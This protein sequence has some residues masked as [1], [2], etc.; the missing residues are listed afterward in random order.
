M[1]KINSQHVVFF[2]ILVGLTIVYNKMKQCD[3]VTSAEHHYKMVDEF[4]LQP[5][6]FDKPY[7]W[8]H[9]HNDSTTIPEVNARNWVS[10]YS[11]DTKD[12][13]QPYQYLT[14]KSIID[15]CGDDFNV[16]IID[17]RSFAK[18][19]PNWKINLGHVAIPIKAHLRQLALMVLVNTYG[20]MIVPSS[21]LC[22][23]SL[24]PLYYANQDQMFVAEFSNQT[25]SCSLNNRFMPTTDFMGSNAGNETLT[26]FIKYL[27]V[28]NSQDFTADRDLVGKPNLWIS[29]HIKKGHVSLVD[30]G[31]IGTKKPCGNTV[32][33]E[34]LLGSTYVELHE[35][36]FGL[37]IPWD[38][39]INR[40]AFQWFVALTPREV[41]E[42]N[43]L[44]AKYLLI[45]GTPR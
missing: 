21:F 41:L 14:V 3:D 43:T 28:L 8:I 23:K 31:L 12:F 26:E 7:L 29:D 9:M 44:I 22:F 6:A 15:K 19:I 37:Y 36:A 40:T 24:K 30:G 16:A 39:F 45:T 38:Q 4:L 5:T 42:S 10:F 11:R 2:L 20:G 18:I 25:S 35:D 13:N 32:E 33:I 17:D 1:F 34:D 27:E